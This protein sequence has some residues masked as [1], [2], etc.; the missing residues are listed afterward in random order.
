MRHKTFE[1]YGY[2]N[3]MK[4]WW[5]RD[6][7]K[8]L[9]YATFNS[10]KN[11][12]NKAMSSYLQ[13]GITEIEENFKRCDRKIEGKKIKDYKLSRFACYLIAMN[14]DIKKEVV[15]KAQVYFAKQAEKIN[16]ARFQMQVIWVYTT[17]EYAK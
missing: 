3:G 10:F 9:G 2:E 16:Y 11:A 8:M 14:C 4:Y 17:K 12:I 1:D 5:A 13:A 15:A 6:Y 7:S